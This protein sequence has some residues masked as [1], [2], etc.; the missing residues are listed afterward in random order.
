M[1]LKDLQDKLKSARMKYHTAEDTVMS[2][3]T[4]ISNYM[5][6]A[7]IHTGERFYKKSSEYSERAAKIDVI[8]INAL[9]SIETRFTIELDDLV[10]K[11]S[12]EIDKVVS[13]FDTDVKT[14]SDQCQS[15][16]SLFA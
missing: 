1:T 9:M 8:Y 15:D 2:T 3:V 6:D 4:E 10:K 14:L 12:G 7:H 5:V 13:E 16:V 11:F